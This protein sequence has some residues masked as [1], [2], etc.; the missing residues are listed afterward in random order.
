MLKKKN[1]HSKKSYQRYDLAIIGTCGL[2]ASY[3]GFETLAENLVNELAS[4]EYSILVIGSI[5]YKKIFGQHWTQLILPF[6]ANGIY[7][8]I[9]DTVSLAIA[10]KSSKLV[11][12]LGIS[13]GIAMPLLRLIFRESRLITHI[14]GLEWSRP[15]WNFAAKKFLRCSERFAIH[16][17]EAFIADNQ[18]IVDYISRDYGNRYLS[19]ASLIAYGHNR[20]DIAATEVNKVELTSVSGKVKKI[21]ATSRFMLVL[22]RAEPENNIELIISSFKS[23][24]KA[25]KSFKEVTLLLVTNACSSDY[26][27]YILNKYSDIPR[28]F[29]SLPLYKNT[30]VSFLRQ[31]CLAYIHGHSAGGSNPSLIESMPYGRPIAALDVPFNRYTTFGTVEY[32]SNAQQLALIMHKILLNPVACG[33][34]AKKYALQNYDW[35]LIASKYLDQF[36]YVNN[37]SSSGRR[38]IIKRLIMRFVNLFR[39]VKVLL[40]RTTLLKKNRN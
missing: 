15:K 14:D 35:S 24:N 36:N 23:L 16:S 7:S 38:I 10:L 20:D 4:P 39:R 21:D 11:L 2:P 12:S 33:N 9:Y 5:G 29:F 25:Q 37:L 17:S 30:E 26:G 19:R 18:G 6:R 32:F 1:T 31:H 13:G 34:K 8:I 40:F 27:K 22:C 3:G 28:I